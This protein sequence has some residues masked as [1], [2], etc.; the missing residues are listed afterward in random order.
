MNTEEP[1]FVDDPRLGK[2]SASRLEIL[3][4]CPGS[5]QL[6][7]TLPPEALHWED[8]YT[9]DG[10]IIH[11]AYET[12]RTL[13]L[14]PEQLE[15]YE[16]GMATDRR[17]VSQWLADFGLREY[18][19]LPREVRLWLHDPSNMKPL[20]SAQLDNHLLAY[21]GRKVVV[22]GNPSVIV[23]RYALVID[24]KSLWC[25]N[26]TPAERNWQ[27]KL[28]AVLAAYEH[29]ASHV[30][31]CFNKALFGSADLV[32]YDSTAL[33]YA[34]QSIFQAIWE[35]EQPGAQL[36]P[37]RWCTH[38]PCKAYCTE[39]VAYAQLPGMTTGLAN[40][41]GQIIEPWELVRAMP[42][43]HL[44]PVWR[45]KG[46]VDKIFKAIKA[47]LEALTDEEVSAIGLR[48]TAGRAND[49][50]KSVKDA[51]ERF[52]VKGY[53]DEELFGCMTFVKGEAVEMVQEHLTCS[54]KKATEHWEMILGDLLIPDRTKPSHKDEE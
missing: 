10:K 52:R 40:T 13:K 37:G 16:R 27:G 25:S 47:R 35:S 31:M 29:D 18:S 46:I 50:L 28:Q 54:K 11:E 51:F 48:R 19:E 9:E 44:A 3:A 39:A 8:E 2:V 4:L 30:R 41:S 14:S 34:R 5:E 12:G 7:R 36:R 42:V 6:R 38:C 26:L 20:T 53:T 49:K 1:G 24:L 15:I 21:K 33:G 22:A 32:D 43:E 45:K 17:L 23:D